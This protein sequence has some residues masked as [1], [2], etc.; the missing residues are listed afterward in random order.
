MCTALTLCAPFTSTPHGEGQG[1]QVCHHQLVSPVMHKFGWAPSHRT[2]EGKLSRLCETTRHRS[3]D[4]ARQGVVSFTEVM[5]TLDRGKDKI[6]IVDARRR[7]G[8]VKVVVG[9]VIVPL[10]RP[11]R[12]PAFVPLVRTKVCY[13]DDD[14]F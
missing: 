11:L 13:H 4:A 10:P 8:E 1:R 2:Q 5:R 3:P 9:T 12:A 14:L 7:M 6:V